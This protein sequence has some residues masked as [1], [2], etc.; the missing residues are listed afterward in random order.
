[1]RWTAVVNPTAG[2]GRTRKLLPRLVDALAG[3]DVDVD[4]RVS[5]DLDDAI[6]IARGAFDD[7]RSVA[8]CAISISDLG[9]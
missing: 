7:G 9:F 3:I 1:M 5:E 8:A 2:R 6:R 4:V